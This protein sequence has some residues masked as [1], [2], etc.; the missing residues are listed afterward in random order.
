[1]QELSRESSR[2]GS[3]PNIRNSSDRDTQ[4]S[5]RDRDLVRSNSGAPNL[6]RELL[7]EDGE[8]RMDGCRD[9]QYNDLVYIGNPPW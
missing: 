9:T 7:R 1:M 8:V 6:E 3:H 5:S 2:E 4:R